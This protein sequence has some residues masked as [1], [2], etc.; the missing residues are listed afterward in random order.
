MHNKYIY[1][2]Y[3]ITLILFSFG[4]C[5]YIFPLWSTSLSWAYCSGNGLLVDPGPSLSIRLAT[6]Q[7]AEMFLSPPTSE[8]VS[9]VYMTMPDFYSCLYSKEFTH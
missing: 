9:Q 8:L 5:R 3:F 7:A 1:C 6:Q 4:V 2:I